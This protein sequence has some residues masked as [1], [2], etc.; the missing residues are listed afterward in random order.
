MYRYLLYKAVQGPDE[1]AGSILELL[2]QVN[3][4][5]RIDYDVIE[6]AALRDE[7]KEEILESLRTISR[8]NGV[9]VVS[10]GRGALPISRTGK[11]GNIS[12]L[13]QVEDGKLKNV[14]PHVKNGKR[15]DCSLHLRGLVQA[16]NISEL[17]DEE[18]ISEHDIS[19]M[20]TSLPEMIEKELRFIETEVETGGG[21]IDAV[22]MDRKGNHLLIE[23]ELKANDNAIAQVQRFKI[24]YSEKFN[25]PADRIKLGIV[26]TDIGESRLTACKSAGINVYKLNL[27]KLT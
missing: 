11:L 17:R 1:D 26:C 23:I 8:K 27:L 13:I 2:E 15:I 14:F 21:R 18:S 7:Q 12:T 6:V 22:F 16:K 10:K 5:H 20:I 3:K 19:R 9:N 24:P 4:K 25:V